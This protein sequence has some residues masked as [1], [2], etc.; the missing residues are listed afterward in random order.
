[1]TDHHVSFDVDA[2]LFAA[3]A[4][5]QSTEETRYY[6]NGVHI[7]PHPDGGVFLVATD[8][9]RMLVCH[10]KSGTIAGETAICQLGKDQ[11][12]ACKQGRNDTA[13]RRVSAA[14]PKDPA[15]VVSDGAPVA[16]MP[17]WRIEGGYPDWR[18]A[19]SRA[20]S[21]GSHEAFDA[22]FFSSFAAVGKM[23]GHDTKIL[24]EAGGDHGPALIRF[25]FTDHVVGL[26][27]PCRWKSET[28]FPD[29][30]GFHPTV[31]VAEEEQ[32]A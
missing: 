21:L 27:T 22:S 25:P 13:P 6:L 3:A 12:K 19:M 23:L 26:L 7:E 9:H 2:T 32:A 4:L 1:M 11:L 18:R 5:F 24:I 8:G 14:G 15:T 29:F 17:R 20:N 30:L 28:G 31:P 10:D 16:V